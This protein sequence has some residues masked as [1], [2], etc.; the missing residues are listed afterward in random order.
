MD[1]E[2]LADHQRKVGGSLNGCRGV[3][4]RDQAA[5]HHAAKGVHEVERAFQDFSTDV[6]EINIHSVRTRSLQL[7]LVVLVFVVYG[8]VESE[9][10]S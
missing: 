7:F 2:A 1:L 8:S 6:L 9:F 10:L 5:H 3:V 4:L